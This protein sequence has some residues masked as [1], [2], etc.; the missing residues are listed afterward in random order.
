MVSEPPL[1]KPKHDAFGRGWTSPGHLPASR[2][3]MTPD[4]P[5]RLLAEREARRGLKPPL[6]T[7]RRVV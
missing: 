3:E 2:T 4:D 1:P 5:D 7:I 6:V